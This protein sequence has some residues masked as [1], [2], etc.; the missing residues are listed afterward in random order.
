[1]SNTE[2]SPERAAAA[3]QVGAVFNSMHQY[4]ENLAPKNDAGQPIMVKQIEYA[5]ARIDEAAMW[6][7]K[8][9]LT[10]GVPPTV[11]APEFA[12]TATSDLVGGPDAPGAV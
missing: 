12:P 2:I 6:A 10:Y 3:Q 7:I 1:M 4:V 11:T 8:S 9:V 5:H